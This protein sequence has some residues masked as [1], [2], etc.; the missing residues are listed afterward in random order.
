MP[1]SP[2]IAKVRPV[3]SCAVAAR[4]VGFHV[5]DRSERSLIEYW[6]TVE[7]R[8]YNAVVALAS[9]TVPGVFDTDI[10][11]WILR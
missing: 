11:G 4:P 7:M 2:R 3:R 10:P 9:L 1:P 6:R 5:R 8:R